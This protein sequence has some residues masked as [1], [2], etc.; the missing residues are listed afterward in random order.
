MEGLLLTLAQDAA[1]EVQQAVLLHPLPA[2][3]T[4]CS[5]TDRLTSVLMP[6]ILQRLRDLL[7]ECAP[8]QLIASL[9]ELVAGPPA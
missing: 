8:V 1:S 6:A 9:S 4:W 7:S 2:V 5:G 3:L